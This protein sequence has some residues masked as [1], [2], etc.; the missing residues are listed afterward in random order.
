MQFSILFLA[1][2]PSSPFTDPLPEPKLSTLN[3]SDPV[4][5][6]T[7]LNLNGGRIFDPALAGY[8]PSY[9]YNAT[10]TNSTEN[11]P[12]ETE[13][14]TVRNV[15]PDNHLDLRYG[16]VGLVLDFGWKRTDESIR[17]EMTTGR[18]KR[19]DDEVIV[20]NNDEASAQG[21]GKPRRARWEKW[22][23]WGD[24]SVTL[25]QALAWWV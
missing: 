19:K 2:S 9:P 7:W 3:P 24:I 17:W 13:V 25:R 11:E 14:D 6:R 12:T 5:N 1:T 4:P 8:Q 16:G 10:K 23:V 22:A 15:I 21:I 20:H 18:G